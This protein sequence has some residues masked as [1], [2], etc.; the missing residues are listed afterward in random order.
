MI[1][2]N[3]SI[4]RNIPAKAVLA[5]AMTSSLLMSACN[6]SKPSLSQAEIIENAAETAISKKKKALS[7]EWLGRNSVIEETAE[8]AIGDAA[9][10]AIGG[11]AQDAIGGAAQDA[12]GGAAGQMLNIKALR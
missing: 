11:A 12:I 9:Q 6:E 3:L 2:K 8:D 1:Q 5:I 7:D 4:N 10:D